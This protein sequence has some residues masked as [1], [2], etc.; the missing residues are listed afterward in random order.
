MWN[1]GSSSSLAQQL[2]TMVLGLLKAV[3]E[4]GSRIP[5]MVGYGNGVSIDRIGFQV[6]REA[7]TIDYAIVSEEG[8]DNDADDEPTTTHESD[9][10]VPKQ[11]HQHLTRSIECALPSSEGW[12]VRL[13]T[14]A[15]SS[16]VE[17]LP[18]TAT[19]TKQSSLASSSSSSAPQESTQTIL[20]LTHASLLDFQSVL[21]V[22]VV[23]ELSGTPGVLRLN[24]LPQTIQDF[25]EQRRPSSFNVSESILKDAG[26][27]AD[28]SSHATP[29]I[30]TTDSGNSSSSVKI[31]T[32]PT[33]LRTSSERSA[34]AEKSVLSRVRRN[35]IYFSSLLQEPEAK[36]KRS[37][38][39]G[40]EGAG[41]ILAR[42]HRSFFL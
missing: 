7:L 12:D 36:W 33:M 37:K 42:T 13:T 40:K 35:Y 19:A 41:S 2:C 17:K 27:I 21:K 6:D 31:S 25:E 9:D 18:W 15:F 29:S 3:K 8:E 1:F 28:L 30:R 4:R 26:S 34:A 22:K 11:E 32:A 14:K 5:T 10:L 23:I 16:H 39:I 38:F 24:G 20:R